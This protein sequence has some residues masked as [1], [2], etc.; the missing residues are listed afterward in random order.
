MT[1]DVLCIG[2]TM[3]LVAP[4]TPEQ[5]TVECDLRLHVAGA[6][7]NVALNLTRLGHTV[8]WASLLGEG[9]FGDLVAQHLND[10]GVDTSL[11]ERRDAPTGAYF[12]NP[13]PDGTRVIYYRTGSAAS[14]MDAA[15]AH[16]WA[17]RT[18][19]RIVHISGITSQISESAGELST[20]VVV[21]RVF[22]D[23]IVSFDV[24]HRP[25]L[26]TAETP[27]QLL[28][29]AR[30]ADI[31]FVGADEALAVWG[32]AASDLPA[33]F[34]RPDGGRPAHI[35]VKD[36]DVD[37]TDHHA[38]GSTVVPARTVDV[39]EP[40]GAGDAFAAGWLSAYL[41]GADAT[42][43]LTRGHTTAARV[44]TSMADTLA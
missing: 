29:L 20:A 15:L 23:A 42:E 30:S 36:G 21:D 9:H 2:E 41:H 14:R 37:A 10:S 40:V 1:P 24:N 4:T 12:K 33:L 38:A 7:S 16:A 17:E 26:A 28:R 19:P 3:M 27:H 39:V 5:L 22:G 18:H 44:L 8:A 35:I 6:E 11:V 43:R 31:V 32:D 25:A 13:G 34:T